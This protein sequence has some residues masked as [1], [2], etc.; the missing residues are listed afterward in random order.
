MRKIIANMFVTLDG[1]IQAPGGP[2]ED[3]TGGF[4]WGGWAVNY[5]DDTMLK[6]MGEFMAKPFDLL[7]GRRTYETFAAHWPYAKDDPFAD[8]L[9]KA[10]KYVVSKTLDAVNWNNSTLII[11][12]VVGKIKKLKEEDG[13][14]LQ[15]H[16]SGTLIQ[17]LLKN[18]L[19]DVFR[20]MT[21]P[22]TVGK[23][24]RL[25]GE[26]TQPFAFKLTD[27]KTSST[28]VIMATYERAGEIKTGSTEFDTPTEAEIARRNNLADEEKAEI[29]N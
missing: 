4:R 16:G 15:V 25:F 29:K 13:S 21:F 9:N 2:Q 23:G 7:L 10:K 8:G 20:I 24:K 19:I 18:D 28:G 26:G 6:N 11:G 5:F 17:T 27:S 3:P 12:D 14:E 1:V 22:M